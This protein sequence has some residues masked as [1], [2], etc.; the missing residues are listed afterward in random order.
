[1]KSSVGLGQ[2]PGMAA[3]LAARLRHAGFPE[4]DIHILPLGETASL[5]VRYRG[6]GTGGRPIL[7][8]THMDVVT[9]NPQRL[10]CNCRVVNSTLWHRLFGKLCCTR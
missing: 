6:D 5:V 4:E 9:A 2:V 1:M 7:F 8:A 3:Y 10:R